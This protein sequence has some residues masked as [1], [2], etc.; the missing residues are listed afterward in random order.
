MRDGCC[1]LVQATVPFWHVFLPWTAAYLGCWYL[2][3]GSGM[4]GLLASCRDIMWAPINQAAF[5]CVMRGGWRG[6]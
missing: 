6:G 5:R 4:E 2:R 3:G 1:T